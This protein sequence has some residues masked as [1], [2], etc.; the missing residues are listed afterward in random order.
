MWLLV[1]KTLVAT[2]N[3]AKVMTRS[4][5]GVASDLERECVL[6]DVEH[7]IEPN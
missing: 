1:P 7:C 3:P 5:G 2:L 4:I 6:P